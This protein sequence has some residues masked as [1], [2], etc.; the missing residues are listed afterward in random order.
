MGPVSRWAVERP[1][2]AVAAWLASAA[3]PVSAAG[4][5]CWDEADGRRACGDRVPPEYARRERQVY[6]KTGR[7][8]FE[9]A[10]VIVALVLMGRWMEGRA[11]KQT[12]LPDEA[13]ISQTDVDATAE[14]ADRLEAEPDSPVRTP[15][16][17]D[18]DR[19]IHSAAF[20][21]LKHKTQ[22]FVEHEGDYFRTR[23]THSIEVAQVARTAW[24][25]EISYHIGCAAE[26]A[27]RALWERDL[28]DAYLDALERHGG[29]RRRILRCRRDCIDGSRLGEPTEHGVEH[30]GQ[31]GDIGGFQRSE[32]VKAG[33]AA[34]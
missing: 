7:V 26:P 20:R 24:H 2:T 22:V 14:L 8:Y 6:D 10:L 16:Q 23:L 32:D 27:S 19:I 17:R 15:F 12:E 1:K 29:P 34:T 31:V 9:T 30:P 21:R 18:R 5:V 3:T 11:K 4:I 25:H 28:L 13:A 33:D